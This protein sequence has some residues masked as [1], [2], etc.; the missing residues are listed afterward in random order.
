MS[1]KRARNDDDGPRKRRKTH[2]TLNFTQRDMLA[3]LSIAADELDIKP[4]KL[5]LLFETA[6][7][8]IPN[9]TLYNLKARIRASGTAYMSD[10]NSGRTRDLS[11]QQHRL[12]VGFALH[13]E[14]DGEQTTRLDG[15]RF[16][17]EK[18]DVTVVEKSVGNYFRAGGLTSKVMRI[19]SKG[20]F[21]SMQRFSNFLGFKLTDEETVDLMVDT[22]KEYRRHKYLSPPDGKKNCSFDFTF[23]TWR[24]FRRRCVFF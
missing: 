13:R 24:T 8:D 4:N 20:F 5:R 10:K 6:G 22:V 23:T 19:K 21:G 15:Q 7:Y 9:R 12:L 2:N 18:L 11:E 17:E 3:R 16:L 1:K 14:L